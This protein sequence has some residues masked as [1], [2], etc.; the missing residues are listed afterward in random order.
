[1]NYATEINSLWNIKDM[2]ILIQFIT[3][4][5]STVKNAQHFLNSTKVGQIIQSLKSKTT[6]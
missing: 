2:D 1:M 5:M 4:Q 3:Q 6:K